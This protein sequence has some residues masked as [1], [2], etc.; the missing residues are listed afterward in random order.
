[1]LDSTAFLATPASM[2]FAGTH[3]STNIVV[4]VDLAS[5]AASFR[6]LWSRTD[7]PHQ[8]VPLQHALRNLKASEC[9][10]SETSGR[11]TSC[12]RCVI[13]FFLLV[14]IGVRM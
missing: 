7:T 10:S 12:S 8:P 1:M 3:G 5:R 11:R 6:Q 9:L 13:A 4:V 2:L 14:R